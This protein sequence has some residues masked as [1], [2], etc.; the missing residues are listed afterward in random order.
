MKRCMLDL[1]TLIT[2][3]SI[4][5]QIASEL[6]IC[7]PRVQKCCVCVGTGQNNGEI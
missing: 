2:Q 4:S 3:M 1:W 6:E 7:T 5:D